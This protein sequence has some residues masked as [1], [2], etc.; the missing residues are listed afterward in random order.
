MKRILTLALAAAAAGTL[1]IAEFADAKRLGGGRSLGTQRQSVAPPPKAPA[2]T[3]APQAPAAT[4][5]T[6]AA[7][8]AAANPV[9][10]GPAAN[11]VMPAGA[12]AAK[13]AP[14]AAAGAA[15]G[16]ATRTGASRWLGPVAGLA[17]GLGLAALASYLGIA[18]ELMSVL[19]IVLFAVA[20][21]AIV[22][23]LM[24]RRSPAQKGMPYAGAGP[25]LGRHAGGYE[26]QVPPYAARDNALGG[27]KPAAGGRVAATAHL[28][29]GF[30][31]QGFL[32]Q[33]K[34]Q[35]NRLQS[36]YDRN[37]TESLADVMTADM[38]AE[39]SAEM[40]GRSQHVATDVVTLDAELLDV[41][42][43]G[44]KHWASVRFQGLTREDGSPTPRPFDEIWNLEKPVD[45]SAGWL[46][47]GIRQVEELPVGH[48]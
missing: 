9:M 42:T 3:P 31:A 39:V 17:A 28:P 24:A 34:A 27:A 13:A 30:D 40:S 7:P 38:F 25:G 21:I 1:V 43:E 20:A 8:G 33:A 48:A 16:A 35:F 6:P 2:A 45:G 11:P 4:P 29:P 26:T 19:L 14:G 36:A 12:A 10:P 15:A 18:E 23:M 32:K 44:D 5:A 47:A 46:L 22:R 41:S 37:D